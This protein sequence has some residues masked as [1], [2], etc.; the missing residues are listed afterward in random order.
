MIFTRTFIQSA[1]LATVL[2]VI[3]VQAVATRTS[4]YQMCLNDGVPRDECEKQCLDN[5]CYRDCVKTGD[6][7]RTCK[8]ACMT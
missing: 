5:K 2:L 3:T 7:P 6:P 1:I 8:K 4:C